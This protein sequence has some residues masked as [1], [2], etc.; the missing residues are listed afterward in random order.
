LPHEDSFMPLHNSD[1]IRRFVGKIV[2]KV[3]ASAF[4]IIRT[5]AFALNIYTHELRGDSKAIR[6]FYGERLDFIDERIK[7]KELLLFLM[8]PESQGGH[9]DLVRPLEP[10]QLD[11]AI[12]A[13]YI[14]ALLND[15][16]LPEVEGEIDEL[17]TEVDDIGGR[18]GFVEIIDNPNVCVEEDEWEEDEEP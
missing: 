15:S 18:I 11:P 3:V 12:A 2:Q 16:H 8:H 1:R 7:K 14:R 9:I 17:Y 10:L 5:Q 4:D 13:E 6:I